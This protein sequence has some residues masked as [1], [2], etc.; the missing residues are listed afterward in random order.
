MVFSIT[1]VLGALLAIAPL[2]AHA[3]IFM[4]NPVPYGPGIPSKSPL[5]ASGYNFPCQAVPYTVNKMNEWPVG[6]NQS[7]VFVGTA[8][9]NGGSCQVSV[10][11]DKAPTKQSKWKVIH[12]FEGGCPLPPKE[13]G[14]YAEGGPGPPP[15]SF[16]IPPE[17]PNGEFSMSWSWNNKI[18]NREFYQDCAPVKVTGGAKDNTAFDAL[19]DMAVANIAGVNSCHSAEGVDYTYE[20]PGKYV[21]KGGKGPFQPLCGGPTTPGTPPPPG[22]APAPTPA[23]PGAPANPGIPSPAASAPGTPSKASGHLGTYPQAPA[24]PVAP[25]PSQ[26]ASPLPAGNGGVQTSTLRTIITVTAPMGPPPA[27]ATPAPSA[28]APSSQ[29]ASAPAQ[30]PAAPPQAPASL[31]Q[32]PAAGGS[33]SPDGQ[34]C[35]PDGSII[36]SSDGT[37]FGLCDFGKA[38]MQPVAGGTKCQGGKIGRRQDAAST[39]RTVYA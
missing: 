10:T 30:A 32:A 8:V 18:G 20:N 13:G 1:S 3:H 37:Q 17:L 6:S 21:T 15:I 26:A 9:H 2:P 29:A 34:T 16:M 39:L 35:S 33:T 12:S 7:V 22:G 23:A 28:A 11:L 31:S 24:A 5:D 25:S 27:G 19:P 4:S 38:V 14:N 36:C